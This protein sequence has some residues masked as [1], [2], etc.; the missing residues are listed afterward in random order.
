MKVIENLCQHF[1]P[2]KQLNPGTLLDDADN[3]DAAT[4][5]ATAKA[6]PLS[7]VS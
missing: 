5:Q 7:N 3:H 4:G 1:D 6:E 2:N